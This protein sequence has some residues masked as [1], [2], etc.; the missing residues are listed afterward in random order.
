MKVGDLITFISQGSTLW[1]NM[2]GLTLSSP[3]YCSRGE[4]RFDVLLENGEIRK[5][6]SVRYMEVLVNEDR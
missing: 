4:K 5:N 3:G 6:M 2:I 1:P